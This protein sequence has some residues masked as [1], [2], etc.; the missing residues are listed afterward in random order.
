M[1][2]H[3][4]RFLSSGAGLEKTLRLIHSL[5]QIAAVFTVGSTAV[6]FTTAK[7]QLALSTCQKSYIL[8][9]ILPRQSLNSN[10]FQSARRFFR[11]FGFIESF[12]RVSTLLGNDGMSSVPGWI[13]LAKWTCF[14]LYFVLEDLTIVSPPICWKRARSSFSSLSIFACLRLTQC[15]CTLW[16]S[17]SSLGKRE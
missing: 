12:H 16:T 2:A 3:L 7:L 10:N 4:N 13:D 5:A 8:R 17:T 11:F 1:V 6:R 14:G 9:S 15:S